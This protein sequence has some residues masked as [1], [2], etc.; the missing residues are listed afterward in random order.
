MKKRTTSAAFVIVVIIVAIAVIV[1]GNIIEK[2]TPSK[3]HISAEELLTIYGLNEGNATGSGDQ[4]AIILQNTLLEEKAMVE[5]GRVYLDYHFVKNTINDKFYW[6]TNE[7][8]LIYTTPIDII[9]AEVGSQDYYVTKAKTTADYVIVK[10]NG[11][12]VYVAL[13]FVKQYSDIAFAYYEN[14]SRV[15]IT[16]EWNVSVDKCALKKGVKIRKAA[17][18][19]SDILYDCK[20]ETPVTILAA[21]NKWSQVVTDDGYFG[22]VKNTELSRKNTVTLTSDFVKPDYS[23][24]SIGKTV[25]MGWHMITSQVANSQLIDL[26]TQAKGLNVVS[27]TW[28]RLSDNEGNMTSLADA[29]YVARAHLV[30]LQV[31]AMVDDQSSESDNKQIFPY[32]SKREKLINQL[33]A[34]AI[35]YDFDGINIDFEYITGDIADDYIQFLRELSVKCRINGIILSVDDKVPDLGNTYYNLKAQGEVA[36]YIIMMGYDEHWGADS[37]AGSVASLP[38][39]EN[40]VSAMAQQVE[41]SKIV[42]AIPFYTRIWT[43]DVDGNVR[44]CSSADMTSAAQALVNHGVE[45]VWVD[46]FGQNYGEYDENGNTVRIWLED[47]TSIE[48]KLKLIQKYQLAGVSAWRLGLESSELWNTIIKYTN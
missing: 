25:S 22:Y 17:G 19:K 32:T 27:P 3:K 7:N 28:Y 14:P 43:E 35:E 18:I 40:G 13:D 42:L 44:D 5:N 29:D 39:V 36:D 6:D 33:I 45:P 8:L 12:Q 46:S 37:G 47:S 31:W 11:S 10:V 48:E 24:L 16:N 23:R 20:E 41:S 2:R 34:N 30:G 15:C 4:A 26:V 9:K 21:E 38:W 1:V